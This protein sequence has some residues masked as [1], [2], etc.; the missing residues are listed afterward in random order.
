ALLAG[1]IGALLRRGARS[2][3]PSD[4]GSPRALVVD[5]SVT[6]REFVAMKLERTGGEVTQVESAGAGLKAMAAQPF[7][8]VML[9]MNLP[10]MHGPVMC[11]R[12]AAVR[13][14]LDRPP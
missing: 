13:D 6:Y 9:D 11:E 3:S 7:D 8:V 4:P 5:D 14:G 2:R 12:F 10:D 1:R